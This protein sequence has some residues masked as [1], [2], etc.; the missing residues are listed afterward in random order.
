MAVI[1]TRCPAWSPRRS[2]YVFIW[3]ACALALTASYLA[4]RIVLESLSLV[5]EFDLPLVCRIFL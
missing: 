4:N 3:I 5:K 1:L 2:G